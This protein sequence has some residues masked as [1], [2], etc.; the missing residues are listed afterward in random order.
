VRAKAAGELY[1]GSALHRA[2]ERPVI[3]ES[4]C[5]YSHQTMT[6]DLKHPAAAV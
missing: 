3:K 2:R 4:I 1:A 6:R 5:Q